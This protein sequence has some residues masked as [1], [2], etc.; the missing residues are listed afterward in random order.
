MEDLAGNRPKWRDLREWLDLVE[1]AGELATIEDATSEKDIGAIT[2]MFEHNEGSPAA[3]FE[4]IP[5]FAPGYRVLSNAMG[6]PARQAITFG[7]PEG[8]GNHDSLLAFWR[9]KM[10]DFTPIPPVV[11]ADGPVRQNILSGDDID[12]TKFPAPI[13]HP[14]DGGRFIGTA[15]IN[16]VRDPDTGIINAGTY[17]NQ[18]FGKDRIGIRAAPPH[19]GGIIK[20]KYL[21]K[22]EPCPIVILVGHDPLLF[23]ASCMEGPAIGDS[24][25]DW[26]GGLRNEPVEV[27]AGEVTGLPIPVN[28]EIALEGY[29]TT[30]EWE[31]EG[32]YGE[33]LGYY[34]DGYPQDNVI[35]IERVY[36]RDN[37]VIL[38]CPQGKPP[39]EDNRFLAYLRAGMIWDQLE[40][41]GV[42]AVKGVWSPPAAGNRLMTVVSIDSQY[43]GHGKQAGLIASQCG[44]GV[45]MNRLTVVVDD[46]VDITNMEDV[47]WA[48][49]ARCDPARSVDIIERTKGAR[50]DIGQAPAD[51]ELRMTSRMIIDATTPFEWKGD[52]LDGPVITTPARTRETLDR[53]GWLLK[54]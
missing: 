54:K 8:H 15:S 32:P 3:L 2:E 7:L 47:M 18:V 52:P 4:K 11:V 42:P 45:E 48:V 53:W 23:M 6:T 5:G 26:A 12:L 9:A 41:A 33:W 27:F 36:H 39:H 46:H 20:N 40:R 38:G 44:A 28:A 14:L 43:A 19:H 49:V 13:W 25:L 21:G 17:R 34:Q 29:I 10:R 22:G 31:K 24:E 35:R 37:P 51:R 16:I 30:D 1:A 50:I